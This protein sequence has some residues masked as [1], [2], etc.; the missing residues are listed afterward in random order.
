[1][2]TNKPY[3]C[4]LFASMNLPRCHVFAAWQRD[5][6]P[7]FQ[8]NLIVKKNHPFFDEKSFSA[9]N[10]THNFLKVSPKKVIIKTDHQ[11]HN[12]SIELCQNIASVLLEAPTAVFETKI[13]QLQHILSNCSE[14]KVYDTRNQIRQFHQKCRC[15][16]KRNRKSMIFVSIVHVSCLHTSDTARLVKKKPRCIRCLAL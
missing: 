7:C 13:K 15:L 12:L 1:M 3:N 10:I 16:I 6:L 14:W 2:F 8:Q 11:K 5:S 9:L 4:Y